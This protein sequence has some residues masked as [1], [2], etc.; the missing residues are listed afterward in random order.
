MY[1]LGTYDLKLV[2]ISVLVAALASYTA[3][4]LA[5]RVRA[6]WF[7]LAGGAASMGTGIWSMH[8]IGMLALRLPI[9]VAY[10][11]P[12][13]MLSML[14][15][16]VV[17]GIALFVVKRPALTTGNLS[18]GAMLMGVGIASMHYTGMAAL[19]MSPPI[20]Y[21][22]LLFI[23]SVMIAIAASLAALWI[24]FRL[25]QQYSGTAVLAKL[26]SAG[27]M[28][29]AIAGMHYTGM[30]A[31][32]FAPD[33]VCLAATSSGGMD[34]AGLAILVSLATLSFLAVTLVIS[35]LE[36]HFAARTAV[37]ADSLRAANEKLRNIALFDAL[38]GLPHRSLLE[39][40]A[41]QAMR[42]AN[43]SGRSVAL[44]FIDLDHFKFVNDSLGHRIGDQLLKSVASRLV[45]CLRQED[46]VA[47]AGG[48]E[49]VILLSGVWHADDAAKIS[50]KIL[51]ELAK[52]LQIERH[53]L[54]I[55][56]S[57]GISMYPENGRDL[58]TLM[59]HADTAMYH[60]KRGGRNNF[61]FFERGMS[62]VV[63]TAA[64]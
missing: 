15:A 57:I 8:F 64:P 10:D 2:A 36:A 5:G 21:D 12:L 48:D 22:P 4:D 46:T 50:D 30:A 37:L 1:M 54:D 25:R 41:E 18:C 33:S 63:R 31:A 53:S 58:N 51:S 60:V 49:F 24:A 6:S 20:S 45:G 17:A 34:S 47:R 16:I 9:P 29:V 56:C 32:S 62:E 55:S 27:V 11:M 40:R 61:C 42:R 59:V 39:D 7:W 19:R 43:R 44:L 3:I 14:I 28:G 52:P 26:G 23:A 38:T 35:S 13:T